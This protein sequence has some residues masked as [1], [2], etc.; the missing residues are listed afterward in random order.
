M[1]GQDEAGPLLGTKSF[2]PRP[3]HGR[4]ERPRLR[5]L[6][7]RGVE[8]K[9]TLV[10]APPGFGKTTLVAEWLA[11]GPAAARRSA[12][13]SLDPADNQPST[14]WSYV[15]AA[16]Q[17]VRS[18]LG[19]QAAT[20]L[21]AP[22][23]P[24]I[25]TVLAAL[26]NDVATLP[27]DVV[28][29][30]D[31]YH[32]IEAREVHDAM[33]FLLDRLPPRLHLVIATRADPAFPLAR[34]RARR[35]LVEI[36]AADLRFTPEEA[37]A[38]LNG[39]MGLHLGASDIA[40][41]ESRT[42]GWIA[43]LQLAALSMEGRDDVTGFIAGFAGDDRYIVDYLVEEVLERQ[44]DDVR[45]FLLETSI[46][47]RLTG[48]LCD[49]VT[50][51]PGGRA[52]LEALD[53][54]NLFLVPLDDRRRWY[55]YHHL[56]ADVL[57]ARLL[58][59]RAERLPELHRRASDWFERDGHPNEA[60]HHALAGGDVA[61]AADL[62]E[63]AIPAMRQGRR[64]ATLRRWFDSLPEDIF[65]DRPVL[66]LGAVGARLVS[67]DIDGVES[68]LR[69]AERWTAADDG[70]EVPGMVVADEEAFRHVPG[71]VAIYR[72][73]LSWAAGDVDS[74]IGQ[75]Q[76]A[77]DLA[78]DDDL[79]ER[80]SAAGFLGLATWSRGDLD[81]AHRWWT[82]AAERL[83]E[84]GHISDVIGCSIALADI[85]L[86]QG[87][88]R[89]A[90]R[91]YERGLELGTASDGGKLRGTSDMH[92]GVSEVFRERNDLARAR[93]HLQA[94]ADL[95]GH[96]GLAQ[97]PY[98]SRVAMAHV[99]ELDG[100]LAGA[101]ALLDEAEEVYASDYFPN[102]RPISAVRARLWIRQ[103]RFDDVRAWARD[104][105]ISAQ[106]D[107]SYL[108]EFEH[109]T[110]ARSL[111]ADT[112]GDRRGAPAPSVDDFLERLLEAAAEGGRGRSVIEIL[113]LQAVARGRRGDLASAL[114]PL[115][116]A[117]ALAEPEGFVRIFL[118]E[119]APM[120]ALLKA[121]GIQGIPSTYARELLSGARPS[122]GRAGV[123]PEL[124]EQLSER[125]AEVLRLLATDLSG[126]EIAAEL[127]VSLNTVRSHTKN[128]Y[129]KLGVNDRRAAVRRAKELDLLS[130]ARS[131]R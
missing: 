44:P 47:S 117:L 104:V 18:G 12:W 27:E 86:A 43:A 99:L 108:R 90:L 130:R 56:F 58:D 76:R 13:L 116:Q 36:R 113:C 3:R 39:A 40:A 54:E 105:G 15:I 59:E 68:R 109:I 91:I 11:A 100:D 79:L 62:I 102:V 75:A 72:A 24:A 1:T 67:G 81:D 128:I 66:A 5:A 74:T 46:L 64:E 121:A 2:V 33:T 96:M 78:V 41:L 34:L 118:D 97:N 29:V 89:D 51:R 4:I 25:H 55:R 73:A 85:R 87:R 131:T 123:R 71:Q 94:S 37:A 83:E 38:Y 107:L 88:L 101:L 14:F 8:S 106:D 30:L 35:D 17:T 110:M 9:L 112:A 77:L 95:D 26:L 53:R 69:D 120:M 63:R 70:S 84:A 10:S 125:E 50:T 119:G 92:V 98:R 48:S 31:D 65:R 32:V 42:E 57:H 82:E 19:A 16:L 49:A 6:L 23:A 28:L 52:M 20:L 61:R 80:G 45:D 93:R 126:P 115:E 122:D 60:I 114:V 129:S 127:V 22:Q 7:D 21:E 103:R 124:P 111:L